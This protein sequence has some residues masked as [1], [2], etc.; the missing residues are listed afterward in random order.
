MNATYPNGYVVLPIEEYNKMKEVM[1]AQQQALDN[2]IVGIVPAY[3]SDKLDVDLNA[4]IVY[5]LAACKFEEDKE[6]V[7][8]YTL[9]DKSNFRAL[10]WS[11]AKLK[12]VG[13]RMLE[14][15]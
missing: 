15:D 9:L 6:L 8:N 11:F 7:D 3:D 14:E 2:L 10:G 12:T 1:E 5:S 13:E 4:D